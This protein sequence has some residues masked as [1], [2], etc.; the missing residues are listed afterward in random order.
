MNETQF[1]KKLKER[2]K[3]NK[4]LVFKIWGNAIQEAGWPDIYIALPGWH[5]WAELKV[6]KNKLSALQAKRLRDLAERDI[7]CCVL[8]E[9]GWPKMKVENVGGDIV[10]LLEVLRNGVH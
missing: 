7:P 5:G 10:P 8:R 6:G 2:L 3:A 9:N 1:G 4:G